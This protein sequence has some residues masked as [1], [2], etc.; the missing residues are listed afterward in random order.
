MNKGVKSL[1]DSRKHFDKCHKRWVEKR[2]R[3]ID[4]KNYKEEWYEEQ[5][6]NCKF[7]VPLIG[8]FSSDYGAC[9]NS[10]SV[11]DKQVMFEH[12]GCENYIFDENYY[13]N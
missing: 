4:S 13:S 8:I 11:F 7:F 12:D 1:A 9:T 6:F 10:E 5:C 2:N 3:D